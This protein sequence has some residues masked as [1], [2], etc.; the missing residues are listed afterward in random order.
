MDKSSKKYNSLAGKFLIASPSISDTRFSKCLIYMVSDN[1]DGSMGV[2]VNKPA[3]NLTIDSI[4]ENIHKEGISMACQPTIYYGGPVDLDKGFI[5]HSN[6]YISKEETTKIEN[7]LLLSN[8]MEILKDIVSGKGPSQSILAIGYAGWYSYQLEDELKNNTWIEADLSVDM[9]FSKDTSNKWKKA[10]LS[11]GIKKN[12][13]K[14]S[15][16][17]P[18]SGS[19]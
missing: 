15:N 5:I 7:N 10:L 8:N 4:F 17:S 16:F 13:I 14:N 9:L 19:A 18:F 12:N 6:D 3:L 1:E 2:I 11:V